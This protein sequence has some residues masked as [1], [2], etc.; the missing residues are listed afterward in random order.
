VFVYGDPL[1]KRFWFIGHGDWIAPNLG[2][3]TLQAAILTPALR[4]VIREFVQKLLKRKGDGAPFSV[5]QLLTRGRLQS[6]DAVK[7]LVFL[8]E[9]YGIDFAETGFDQSQV[10]SVDCIVAMIQ[11]KGT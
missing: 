8:E 1:T 6:I 10:E 2:V 11:T 5:E 4:L 9:K 3:P 7:V